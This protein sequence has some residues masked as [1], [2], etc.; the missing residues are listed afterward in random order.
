MNII[1]FLYNKLIDNGIS[2]FTAL[3]CHLLL[4][5]S[6]NFSEHLNIPGL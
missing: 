2:K 5:P 3:G 6:R 4:L 1:Y